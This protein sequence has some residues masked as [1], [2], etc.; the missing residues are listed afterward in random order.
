MSLVYRF[1]R[2]FRAGD[3]SNMPSSEAFQTN[4]LGLASPRLL[5]GLSLAV[6]VSE[7]RQSSLDR[8]S[9]VRASR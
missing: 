3:F 8:R 2:L 6:I 4:G 1:Q 7:A 9:A 5:H